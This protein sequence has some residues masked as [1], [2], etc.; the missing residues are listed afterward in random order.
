MGDMFSQRW[1]RTKQPFTAK[2]VTSCQ[3]A[4]LSTKSFHAR[5]AEMGFKTLSHMVAFMS[6]LTP[7]SSYRKARVRRIAQCAQLEEYGPRAVIAR[8]NDP[9]KALYVIMKGECRVC[10]S[11]AV[12]SS[13]TM[14]PSRRLDIAILSVGDMFNEECLKNKLTQYSI[15][16]NGETQVVRMDVDMVKKLLEGQTQKDLLKQAEQKNAWRQSRASEME[17]SL[18]EAQKTRGIALMQARPSTVGTHHDPPCFK[19][20]NEFADAYRGVLH[21]VRSSFL[22]NIFTIITLHRHI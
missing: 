2:A 10:Y 3:L 18:I 22:F 21:R 16:S 15:I 14:A 6:S 17:L 19:S 5:L 13:M 4:V 12:T 8:Q 20:A 7:F 11:P 9:A 1:T